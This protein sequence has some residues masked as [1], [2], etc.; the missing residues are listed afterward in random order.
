MLPCSE[1]S[2]VPATHWVEIHSFAYLVLTW[3]GST[4]RRRPLSL[5]DCSCFYRRTGCIVLH[6]HCRTISWARRRAA[7]EA[8]LGSA[9]I[10]A[11]VR[12]P[13]GLWTGPA[14]LSAPAGGRAATQ[15]TTRG[16]VAKHRL[17]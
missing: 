7:R 2:T 9:G 6:R 8:S 16:L 3:C 14:R 15:M 10:S 13:T 12:V 1:P 11:M 5:Y 4:S 17:L